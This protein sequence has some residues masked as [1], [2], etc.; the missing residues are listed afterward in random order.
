MK[1]DIVYEKSDIL[2]LVVEDLRRKGI[3]VKEGTTPAVK[4]PLE[5]KLSIE[6]DD[7]E[8]PAPAP[9]A[10]KP[11]AAK[12]TTPPPSDGT[13]PPETPENT[14]MGDVL[15]QSNSLVMTSPGKFERRPARALGPQES[16]EY[17]K[18]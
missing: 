17:P 12:P 18:E 7:D 14:D 13:K 1:I 4:A 16:Y 11:A 3:K 10:A 5:V 9:A 2:K 15:N 8:V 6:A